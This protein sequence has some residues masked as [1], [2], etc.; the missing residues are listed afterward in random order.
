MLRRGFQVLTLKLTELLANGVISYPNSG[1]EAR[2]FQIK[3]FWA[4][5]SENRST[6]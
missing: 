5:D 6:H 4:G 3:V 1:S 2:K